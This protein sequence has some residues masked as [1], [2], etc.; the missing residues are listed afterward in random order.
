[1]LARW[2]R[3]LCQQHLAYLPLRPAPVAEP[4]V[5]MMTLTVSSSVG[6]DRLQTLHSWSTPSLI[7]GRQRVGQRQPGARSHRRRAAPKLSY[8]TAD[9]RGRQWSTHR[10][11][12]I[13]SE[14]VRRQARTLRVSHPRSRRSWPPADGNKKSVGLVR[15]TRHSS[16]RE[17]RTA[18]GRAAQPRILEGARLGSALLASLL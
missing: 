17:R 15:E 8:R 13:H 12:S 18:A 5:G 7:E 10:S 1:M 14:A 11:R 9:V 3:R 4:N 2:R 6:G 16:G